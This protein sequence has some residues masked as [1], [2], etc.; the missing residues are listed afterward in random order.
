VDIALDPPGRHGTITA[1]GRSNA[2]SVIAMA[3]KGN[4]L[5]APDTYMDKIAVGPSAKGAIDLTKAVQN[6]RAIAD[7]KGVYVDDL[8]VIILNRR[9][10]EAHR[11]GPRNRGAHQLMRRRR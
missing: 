5:N 7:R 6:L 4:L 9:A 10:R 3:E 2:L 8:T 11:R 1:T